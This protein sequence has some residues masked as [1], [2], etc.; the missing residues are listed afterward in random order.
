MFSNIGQEQKQIGRDKDLENMMS[1]MRSKE[2]QS[3]LQDSPERSYFAQVIDPIGDLF[4]TVGTLAYGSG[5]QPA[6]GGGGGGS[7]KKLPFYA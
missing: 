1:Y 6:I 4:Q 7:M 2:L 3:W 5:D